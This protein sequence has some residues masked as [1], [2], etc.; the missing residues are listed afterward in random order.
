MKYLIA[1][2]PT[3]GTGAVAQVYISRPQSR[4]ASVHSFGNHVKFASHIA[5]L[6]VLVALPVAA[7]GRQD[8][9]LRR[10]T[11]ALQN[12]TTQA[13]MNLAS[14][15]IADYWDKVLAAAQAKI[16]HNLDA[17]EHKQFVQSHKHWLS[18]R[19]NEVAFRAVFYEGGSIQPLIA[20]TA[21]SEITEHRVSELE[22]LLSEALAGRFEP[23]GA[24]KR[25]QAVRS[26]T[27][28]TSPAAGSGR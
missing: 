20:N 19:T 25:S 17:R 12:A 16:E 9:E 5:L 11:S 23:V 18:Y 10:L 1:K 8:P 14:K 21:Y 4:R 15:K 3:S 24:A 22:S 6:L 27:N 7:A 28:K 26:Q 13:D 2:Q